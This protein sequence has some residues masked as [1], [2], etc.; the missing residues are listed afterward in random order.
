MYTAVTIVE[1]LEQFECKVLL[2]LERHV[3]HQTEKIRRQ[4]VHSVMMFLLYHFEKFTHK[5]GSELKEL[6]LL[7]Q[8]VCDF[9][10]IF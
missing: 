2:N 8:R 1:I 3:T 4:E 10:G 9:N 7:I 6:M 5:K